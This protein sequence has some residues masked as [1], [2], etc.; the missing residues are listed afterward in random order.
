MVICY[1][2]PAVNSALVSPRIFFAIIGCAKPPD[3]YVRVTSICPLQSALLPPEALL[4]EFTAR[5]Q[6]WTHCSIL[7]GTTNPANRRN[8]RC[9]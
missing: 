2:K 5:R 7:F 1:R 8:T 4:A 3:F 6:C 9:L